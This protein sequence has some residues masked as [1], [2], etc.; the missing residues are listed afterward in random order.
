MDAGQFSWASLGKADYAQAHALVA[1]LPEPIRQKLTGVSREVLCRI[2]YLG[3]K[4]SERGG[5]RSAY[6][7]PSERYLGAVCHRS[8]RT[9]RRSLTVLKRLGLVTWRPRLNA[10]KAW[11]TNL[12]QMGRSLLASLFAR[13]ARKSKQIQARTFL[14]DNDLKKGIEAAPNS[15]EAA[16]FE[17]IG[18]E[19]R[20]TRPFRPIGAT[21][22]LAESP[23]EEKTRLAARRELLRKQGEWLKARGL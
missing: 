10:L 2:I 6:C 18:T 7:W 16:A 23:E 8:E 20:Q 4:Q 11:T 21:V 12:Y 14:S 19:H 22:A 5:R 15:E 9:V 3:W 17:Y 13:R 1:S